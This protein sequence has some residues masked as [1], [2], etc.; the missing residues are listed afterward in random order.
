MSP[1]V[2]SQGR[3]H[4]LRGEVSKMHHDFISGRTIGMPPHLETDD[5]HVV[6]AA[7]DLDEAQVRGLA[8]EIFSPGE[9]PVADHDD[10]IRASPFEK[11][12]GEK[13]RFFNPPGH[14]RRD[15]SS[16][17]VTEPSL[18]RVKGTMRRVWA[19]APMSIIF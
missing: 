5:A 6:A 14:V 1:K 9:S 7:V 12:M 10:M 13:N 16:S 17:G 18:V 11:R 4:R 15:H 19:P 2:S 8:G 3:A